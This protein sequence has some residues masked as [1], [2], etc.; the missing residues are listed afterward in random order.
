MVK[1]SIAD[2]VQACFGV[3]QLE[4]LGTVGAYGSLWLG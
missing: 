4:V 3:G 2:N 1:N